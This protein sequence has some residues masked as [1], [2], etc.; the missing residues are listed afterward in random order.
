MRAASGQ[1]QEKQQDEPGGKLG[2]DI[3][4]GVDQTLV[5]QTA[6]EEGELSEADG[7]GV[8][9]D[10]ATAV[11][12]RQRAWRWGL[13]SSKA[14]EGLQ[15]GRAACWAACVERRGVA[16]R[17]G[18]RQRGDRRPMAIPIHMEEGIS[19]ELCMM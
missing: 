5:G 6:A 11:V 9:L 7:M 18:A 13:H 12:R 16:E 19:I 17:I 1:P 14:T 8:S 2:A 3:V 15:G 10:P 4:C